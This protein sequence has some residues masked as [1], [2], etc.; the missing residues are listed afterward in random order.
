MSAATVG[1]VGCLS[2]FVLAW[3]P[4]ETSI[5][6]FVIEDAY[7]YLSGARHQIES[8]LISLDGAHATNGFHPLWMLVCMGLVWTLGSERSIGRVGTLRTLRRATPATRTGQGRTGRPA[9]E[10]HSAHRS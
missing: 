1:Y 8:G 7:Y 10:T 5:S 3:L 6:R 2:I 9:F 4:L